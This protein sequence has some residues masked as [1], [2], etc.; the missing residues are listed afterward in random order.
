MIYTETTKL[1]TEIARSAFKEMVG[2]GIPPHPQHF[3]VWYEYF[4]GRN[5]ELH[6]AIDE[7][8]QSGISVGEEHTRTLYERFFIEHASSAELDSWGARIEAT[9]SKI[10]EAL[11]TAG[12]NTANY[13]AALQNFSGNLAGA[14]S[15]ADIR[16]LVQ[17]ILSATKEMDGQMR[18][19]QSRVEG[20][21]NEVT[22]LR[23]KLEI[24]RREALTDALTGIANRKC[25]EERLEAA[26][27][28]ADETREPL[29]LVL[30]DIDHFK[31]L[32]DTYGHP[33]GDQ[34]LKLVARTVF[35]GV[36]GRDTAARFGGEEF[37][38]ILPNTPMDGAVVVAEGLRKA[39][40]AKKLA[41]KG[42]DK[43]LG[44]ITLS[45]G[46]TEYIPGEPVSDLVRR[47]DDLLY[48]AKRL[49]RNRVI[50]ENGPERVA[51]AG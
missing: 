3:T 30:A 24:T 8:R 21:T 49:G 34:V 50:A 13:G 9:A 2:A 7:M 11:S 20:A 22:E 23:E 44:S 51:R 40:A 4:S 12:S 41:R 39:I 27:R 5:A 46:A 15:T 16:R 37:A 26:A 48:R 42:S 32:N 1:A 31:R 29:S 33:V 35:E 6:R 17:G 45:F 10:I 18:R 19:L 36:R 38:L 25:F 47:V 28:L 14:E 43:T